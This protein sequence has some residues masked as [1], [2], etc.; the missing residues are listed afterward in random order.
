MPRIAHATKIWIVFD[1]S[2]I[3]NVLHLFWRLFYTTVCDYGIAHSFV[4]G[5]LIIVSCLDQPA[6]VVVLRRSPAPVT[7]SSSSPSRRADGTLPRPSLDQE[8]E[9]LHR[10][11]HVHNME[12]GAWI[13]QIVKTFDY[14]IRVTKHFR[15]R[16][17]RV[18]GHTLPGRCYASPR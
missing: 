6:V 10:A 18:R 14:F 5:S 17:T 11:E 7:S 4:K 1:A 8:Y 16:S 3:A 15:F 12:F 2:S 9:G 13:G